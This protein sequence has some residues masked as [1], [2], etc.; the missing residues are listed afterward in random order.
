MLNIT[1]LDEPKEDVIN[2]DDI[3]M[4]TYFIGTRKGS[5]CSDPVAWRKDLG[6]G[7]LIAIGAINSSSAGTRVREYPTPIQFTNYR[8]IKH[9]NI[10]IVLKAKP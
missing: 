3:P 8:E 5:S 6:N 9:M 4:G 2:L 1:I 10:E 7:T